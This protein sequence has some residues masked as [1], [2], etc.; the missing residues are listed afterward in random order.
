LF[1]PWGTRYLRHPYANNAR[2]SRR[3]V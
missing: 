2:I 1:C 3:V